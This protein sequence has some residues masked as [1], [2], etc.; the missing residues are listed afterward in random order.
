MLAPREE[1]FD[2][3]ELIKIFNKPAGKWI[4]Q[5]KQYIKELQ[6]ENPH[7]SKEEVI[8]KLKAIFFNI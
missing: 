1:L 3:N 4:T 5:T 8:K 2:G 7:I 6:F